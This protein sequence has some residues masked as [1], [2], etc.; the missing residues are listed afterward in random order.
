[1]VAPV[2][3]L[4]RDGYCRV[5]IVE[6]RTIVLTAE[7]H[8]LDPFQVQKQGMQ[9]PTKSHRNIK[10]RMCTQTCDR[11]HVMVKLGVMA[12]K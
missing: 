3:V 7:A 6:S 11:T 4:S 8:L 10:W 12:L 1:M 2:E 9:V 5:T